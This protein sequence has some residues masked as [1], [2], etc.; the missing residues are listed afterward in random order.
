VALF[1]PTDAARVG[2]YQREGDVIQ[3]REPGD[4]LNHKT[5]QGAAMMHRITVDEVLQAC[6][7]RLKGEQCV[8]A[9]FP[10]FRG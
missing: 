9:A 1:G 3:H 5:A 8:P 10:R 4:A 2:P 6:V 7:A